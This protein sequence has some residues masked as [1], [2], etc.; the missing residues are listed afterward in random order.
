MNDRPRQ[1]PAY[2]RL[3]LS[4]L[5]S[6]S[7]NIFQ[8]SMA[9]IRASLPVGMVGKRANAALSPSGDPFL[10]YYLEKQHKL[11]IYSL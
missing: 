5:K 6:I 9:E 7:Y 3:S 4:L 8:A 2:G 11:L 10:T 1:N